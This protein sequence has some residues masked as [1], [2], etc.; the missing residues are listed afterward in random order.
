LENDKGGI[1]ISNVTGEVSGVT[2]G[3]T[4][5]ITGKN[6]GTVIKAQIL[7][8][9]WMR[10]DSYTR[11]NCSFGARRNTNDEYFLRHIRNFL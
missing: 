6:V 8:R 9:G 5:N 7:L 4:G 11:R 3:G 1:H 10:N 2:Y